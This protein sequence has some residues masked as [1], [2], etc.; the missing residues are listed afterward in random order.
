MLAS[1]WENNLKKRERMT[2]TKAAAKP[3]EE[4]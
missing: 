2:F 3:Q 4:A 1:T